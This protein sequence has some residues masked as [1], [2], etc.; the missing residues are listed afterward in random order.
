MFLILAEN[1]NKLRFPS[2][3]SSSIQLDESAGE[4]TMYTRREALGYDER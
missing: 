3:L 2:V 1:A 4:D